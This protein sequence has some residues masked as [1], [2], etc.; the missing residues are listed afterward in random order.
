MVVCAAPLDESQ[1]LFDN[2]KIRASF[3]CDWQHLFVCFVP[4]VWPSARVKWDTFMTE[5][6]A[7]VKDGRTADLVSSPD[8]SG[9]IYFPLAQ[10]AA[11]IA[12]SLQ[13]CGGQVIPPTGYFQQVAQYV[14]TVQIPFCFAGSLAGRQSEIIT[15]MEGTSYM[16]VQTAHV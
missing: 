1:L 2:S 10:I 15:W 11:F 7:Q 8:Q 3:L 14:C 16:S 13:S 6:C 4:R 9:L 5:E 12:E